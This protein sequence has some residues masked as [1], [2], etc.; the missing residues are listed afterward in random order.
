MKAIIIS[1]MFKVK[2]FFLI[3]SLF[4]PFKFVFVHFAQ[5]KFFL[6]HFAV[7]LGSSALKSHYQKVAVIIGSLLQ[8]LSYAF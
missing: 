6:Q 5:K 7:D 3:S 2:K 4:Y 1:K 8:K